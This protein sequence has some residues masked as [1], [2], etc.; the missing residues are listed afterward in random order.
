MRWNLRRIEMIRQYYVPGHTAYGKTIRRP[1]LCISHGNY[2]E[3]RV[4]PEEP[5]PARTVLQ[6]K[7]LNAYQAA[8]TSQICEIG[9]FF[10]FLGQYPKCRSPPNKLNTTVPYINLFG[11]DFDI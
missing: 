11:K 3:W 7:S 2:R 1:P 5:P 9:R 4:K 10:C 8:D 6:R